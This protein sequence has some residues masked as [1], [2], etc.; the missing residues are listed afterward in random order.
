MSRVGSAHLPYVGRIVVP[1]GALAHTYA[2]ALLVG[3]WSSYRL[4]ALAVG[5]FIVSA[6][7]LPVSVLS[8]RRPGQWLSSRAMVAAVIVVIGVDVAMLVATEPDD[9]LGYPNW[10]I[11]ALALTILGLAAY[12]PAREVVLLAAAHASLVAIAGLMAGPLDRTRLVDIALAVIGASLPAVAALGF[13]SWYADALRARA[14]AVRVGVEAEATRRAAE[15]VAID[16]DRR[17]TELRRK[18]LPLLDHVAGGGVL[19]L[20]TYRSERARE[21]AVGLRV[22]L[23]AARS[24]SWLSA[25]LASSSTTRA[26]V[27]DG[28]GLAHRLDASQRTALLTAI[29]ALRSALPHADTTVTAD[30][31]DDGDSHWIVTMS[32]S[33]AASATDDAVVRQAMHALDAS[34]SDDGPDR[35]VAELRLPVRSSVEAR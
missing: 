13:L 27:A 16:G 15:V 11:G 14:D 35:V 7:V 19:P 32:G 25:A 28:H 23:V 3:A 24:T 29:N 5:A 12:R 17:L 21:I 18:T 4:P 33:R 8:A 10:A 1:C 31:D 30:T 26:E 20:D 9:W 6:C 34:L 2:L 22:E